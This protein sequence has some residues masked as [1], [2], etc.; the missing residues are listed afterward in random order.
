MTRIISNLAAH[1]YQSL[2]WR[3]AI[4]CIGFSLVLAVL[5]G[6]GAYATIL[7]F[8]KKNTE[9]STQKRVELTAQKIESALQTLDATTESLSKN[10]LVVNAIVDAHGR[11]SYLVPFLQS[12]RLPFDVPHRL[13]LCDFKGDI[14]ASSEPQP[15]SYKGKPGLVETTVNAAKPVASLMRDKQHTLLI[16]HPVIYPATGTAEG[17]LALEIPV[18]ALMV[19]LK[20]SLGENEEGIQIRSGKDV[21]WSVG[22]PNAT[23]P[24]SPLSFPPPL[25]ALQLSLSLST[26]ENQ[27]LTWFTIIFIS[28]TILAL[29]L[30]GLIAYRFSGK[31]TA[32]LTELDNAVSTITATGMPQGEVKVLGKDEVGRLAASFNSMINR[33]RESYD[34][35]ESEVAERTSELA[36]VNCELQELVALR[37]SELERTNNELAVFCYAISHELRAPV[38]RLQGFSDILVN[39]DPDLEECHFIAKRIDVASKQLQKVIDAILLLSRLSRIEMTLRETDFSALATEAAAELQAQTELS[40]ATVTIQQG[41]SCTADASLMKICLLNMISNALK[42]SSRE[43]TPVVEI[44]M[45][46]DGNSCRYFVRDNGAGFNM[47]YVDKLFVPFQR[48]HHQDDFPGTGI[49]LATVQRIVER[50]NGNV[51]AEGEEGVGATFWFTLGKP[52][53][54]TAKSPDFEQKR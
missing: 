53:S 13:S 48:L 1:W 44:G 14:I 38:A 43:T 24:T 20:I 32:G 18:D 26:T 51:W 17:F 2:T 12:S 10:T 42:F 4:S 31:L 23:S 36:V 16:C 37:S 28:T 25:S 45:L 35:L 21:V 50:H 8:I 15:G 9:I 6:A 40:G 34:I 29:Y 11:D 46:N 41:I 54:S 3:I 30:S 47:E 52:Y 19:K 27:A 39:G 49:G 33:L 22:R 5:Y 7:H